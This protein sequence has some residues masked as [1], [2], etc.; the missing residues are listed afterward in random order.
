MNRSKQVEKLRLFS[1]E[2]DLKQKESGATTP[3]SLIRRKVVRDVHIAMRRQQDKGFICDWGCGVWLV[4]GRERVEHESRT[5]TKR[6]IEC[7]QKCGLKIS[8]ENWLKPF[9]GLDS[10]GV[11]E[12]N[13]DDVLHPLENQTTDSRTNPRMTFQEHH[14]AVACPH[15]PVRCPLKCVEM[16]PFHI[17]DEHIQTSCVKR[18]ARPF[19]CSLGCGASYGGTA[20]DQSEAEDDVA[21]HEVEECD[22]RK[23]SDLNQYRKISSIRMKLFSFIFNFSSFFVQIKPPSLFFFTWSPLLSPPPPLICSQPHDTPLLYLALTQVN[24]A[25]K[26]PNGTVCGASM[27]AKDRTAHRDFHVRAMGVEQYTVA[28]THLFTVPLGVD[29]LKVQIWGAGGGSGFFKDRKSG[30][31]GGGAFVEA[32]LEVKPLDVLEVVVGGGG[33][34]GECG[35]PEDS[36]NVDQMRDDAHKRMRRQTFMTREQRAIDF[37]PNTADVLPIPLPKTRGRSGKKSASSTVSAAQGEA[38]ELL[39]AD[40]HRATARGGM[41]G[42]GDGYGGHGVWGGGGGGGY[43]LLSNRTARG[44]Q[45]LLVAAGGGGGGSSDGCP[46]GGCD[47]VLP[48]TRMQPHNGQ[49]ATIHNPGNAGDSGSIVNAM[50]AGRP[51]ALWLGGNGS[52]FGGG[53]GGGYFGGGG[54]IIPYDL[55]LSDLCPD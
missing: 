34:A 50:W 33:A 32:L 47:G 42:G 55:M 8:E 36:L 13:R 5:C 20:G 30:T 14:E 10:E 25:W 12:G 49:T 35:K 9:D 38:A 41:P 40:S 27:T 15:R 48:G 39:A 46:G 22:F 18:P 4:A 3:R 31:G 17:L 29:R 52:E 45:A 51:G 21:V 16:V 53:G 2:N 7:I 54:K 23:V 19:V 44:S 43:S 1:I 24:C 6:F 26:L 28:G 11:E 37:S